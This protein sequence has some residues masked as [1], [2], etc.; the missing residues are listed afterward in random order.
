MTA[1]EQAYRT[2][3]NKQVWALIGQY[4]A[5][6]ARMDV[7]PATGQAVLKEHFP[8]KA[9]ADLT[10]SE[11]QQFWR[12]CAER[13]VRAHVRKRF[14]SE[15]ISTL[16]AGQLLLLSEDIEQMIQGHPPTAAPEYFRSDQPATANQLNYIHKLFGQLG[17]SLDHQRNFTARILKGK[18][19]ADTRRDASSLIQAIQAVIRSAK[20]EFGA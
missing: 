19:K 11:E 15:H 20:P 17:W 18:T 2:K 7:R 10:A 16:R 14:H 8:G 3:K 4:A 13:I 6:L 5:A 12:A 9:F 1:L